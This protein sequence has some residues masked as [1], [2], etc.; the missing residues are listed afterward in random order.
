MPYG[1]AYAIATPSPPRRSSKQPSN[2]RRDVTMFDNEDDDSDLAVGIKIA[3]F[4]IHLTSKVAIIW[5]CMTYIR[6]A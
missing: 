1:I 2:G 4:V 3:I 5:A 6:N